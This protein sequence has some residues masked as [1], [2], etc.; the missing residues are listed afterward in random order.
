MDQTKP[1]YQSVL[2]Q[3]ARAIAGHG[4]IYYVAMASLLAVFVADD[5][6][7]LKTDEP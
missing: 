1:D 3:L 2:S 5:G 4:V 6:A 7:S